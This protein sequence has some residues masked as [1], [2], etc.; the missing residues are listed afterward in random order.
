MIGSPS[1][2]MTV[3]LQFVSLAAMAIILTSH[4]AM[5]REKSLFIAVEYKVIDDVIIWFQSCVKN[6]NTSQ[7][8]AK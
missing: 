2:S 7:Q 5:N 6:V 8:Y 3:P 1:L 4:I